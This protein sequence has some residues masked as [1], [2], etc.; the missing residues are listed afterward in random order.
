MPA[1]CAYNIP[2]LSHKV[3]LPR[4]S[5]A[6]HVASESFKYTIRAYDIRE[7]LARV[8]HWIA[9][10]CLVTYLVEI[11]AC[12]H[13][14]TPRASFGINFLQ[15]TL[16]VSVLFSRSTGQHLDEAFMCCFK[17][18]LYSIQTSSSF[19]MCTFHLAA[20]LIWTAIKF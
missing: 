20:K 3:S 8:M 7:S 2:C 15:G 10:V 16:Q 17:C 12:F 13:S 11:K 4:L 6:K 1:T 18:S 5:L 9:L 14:L 19:A